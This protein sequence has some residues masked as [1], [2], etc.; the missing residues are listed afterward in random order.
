M[1]GQPRTRCEENQIVWGIEKIR[2]ELVADRGSE[3]VDVVQPSQ[4]H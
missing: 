2:L 4:P 3:N 1:V